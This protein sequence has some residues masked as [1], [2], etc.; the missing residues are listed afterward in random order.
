[1]E[2]VRN[3]YTVE[4]GE[5][6]LYVDNESRHRSGHMT[7]GLAEFAPGKIIDFNSNCSPLR[8]S[9]HSTFGFVEY[10]ISEDGGETFSEIYQLPYS[11]ECLFDGIHV[12]SVEKAVAC[13]G[14]IVAFC[15]RNCATSLC[16]PWDTPMIVTSDD[17]GKSWSAP[18]E[19]CS[20]KGRIYDARCHG[21][22]IYALEFCN[23][24]ATDFL[25][26]TEEHVYRIFVSR[27]KGESFEELCVPPLPT[28]GRAYGAMLFDDKGDLH[29]YAYN[30]NDEEH[31]D[32]VVSHDSGLTWDAP[33]A[34]FMKEGIRNPQVAQINGIFVAHGRSKGKDGFVV[35][36]SLDGEVWDEGVYIAHVRGVCYYSNSIVLKDAEGNDRLL[37][38]YSENY[39]RNCVNV[40]HVWLK[41][42]K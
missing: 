3:G 17:G 24:A 23:D 35:Y 15:L 12:I 2:I 4:I 8:T 30:A 33:S 6:T 39:E 29:L 36:T 42:K 14:R 13:E 31:I 27:D 25:G 37:I 9:G 18:R 19:L 20:F 34:C 40:K 28:L 16:T 7:H 26:Q 21:G 10:K 11:L 32:H 41:I 38:Q 22:V 1:M 5:P